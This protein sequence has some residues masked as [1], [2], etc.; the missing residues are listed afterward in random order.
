MVKIKIITNII[1]NYF[2]ILKTLNYNHNV[3]K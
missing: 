1:I 2:V 3:A